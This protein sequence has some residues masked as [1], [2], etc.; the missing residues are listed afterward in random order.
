MG[1]V[2]VNQ[3][4][5]SKKDMEEKSQHKK[6]QSRR[7]F[8]T[9][10]AGAMGAV[11]VGGI[12]WPFIDS[13]N[14]AEDVLALATVDV[15]LSPI[16]VGQAITVMWQGKPVFIRHRS[17]EDVQKVRTMDEKVLLDP[18]DDQQRVKKD[19]WLVVIGIC[20]HLGCVPQGQK[21]GEN[22]GSFDGWFCPCHGSEYDGSGRVCRG[23]AP[24][25]LP[26]PYYEFIDENTIRIGQVDA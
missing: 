26:V 21:P 15:D 23:P 1:D 13:M 18:E 7:D 19:Q 22:K 3:T 24:K 14:P 12:I 11:G 17:P 10:A 9:I 25:N 6:P 8:L 5:S 2:S 16:A 4:K 20:T